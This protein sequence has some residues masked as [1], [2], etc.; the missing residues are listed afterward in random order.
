M[1]KNGIIVLVGSYIV[2]SQYLIASWTSVVIVTIVLKPIYSDLVVENVTSSYFFVLY[3]TVPLFIM[4]AYLEVV[5]WSSAIFLS[6][7]VKSLGKS[8]WPLSVGHYQ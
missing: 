4:K 1:G 2:L 6:T 5:Y 8:L 7:S 3:K